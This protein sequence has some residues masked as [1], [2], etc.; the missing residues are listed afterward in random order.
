MT[1]K[2]R[3]QDLFDIAGKSSLII[4]ATGSLGSVAAKSLADAGAVVVLSGGNH[5]KLEEIT[6][7]INDAGGKSYP[8]NLRPDSEENAEAIIKKVLDYTGGLDILIVASGYNKA[9]T[10]FD[11][12]LADFD[13][14]QDANVRQVWLI[15]KK[16][17]EAMI[18][19]DRKGKIVIIS[20]VRGKVAAE[21][22]TAYC[23]SKAAADMLVKCFATEFGPKGITVNAI[24]PTVFRSP[25]TAWLYAEEGRGAKLREMVLKRIPLGRLGE[26]EDF[27]GSLIYCSSKASGFMTGHIM[28]VDGGFVVD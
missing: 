8:I 13:A 16:A 26:P 21:N 15:C 6:Q 28:Y 17:G 25:L 10:V 27:I 24:A 14:V 18:D 4:G 5:D 3:I 23:S 1:N 9:G 2:K 11:L 7:S 12:S 19:Q 22:G 20:S